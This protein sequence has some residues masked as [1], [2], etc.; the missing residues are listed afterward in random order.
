[1]REGMN[2]V[3]LDGRKVTIRAATPQGGGQGGARQR[4]GRQGRPGG[5]RR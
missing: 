4:S 5:R 2:N 1:M 3:K